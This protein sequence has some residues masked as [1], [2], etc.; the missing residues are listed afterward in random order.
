LVCR[1][2]DADQVEFASRTQP[3]LGIL[4]P[5]LSG[6]D[7]PSDDEQQTVGFERFL[8]KVIRA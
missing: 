5:Q 2:R 7:R 6:L 3:Q 1:R 4:A 8:K